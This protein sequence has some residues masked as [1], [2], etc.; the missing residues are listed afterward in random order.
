MFG[1]GG[2]D[3][4]QSLASPGQAGLE[5]VGEWGESS[6]CGL[7]AVRGSEDWSELFEGVL[8]LLLWLLSFHFGLKGSLLCLKPPQHLEAFCP[9]HAVGLPWQPVFHWQIFLRAEL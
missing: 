2:L 5:R 1:A 8:L 4:S 7:S 6:G 3:A 9:A